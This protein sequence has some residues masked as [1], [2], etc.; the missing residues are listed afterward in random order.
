MPEKAENRKDLTQIE[1]NF[2]QRDAILLFA[3]FY[4]RAPGASSLFDRLSNA[5]HVIGCLSGRSGG[6]VMQSLQ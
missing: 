3:D 6:V 2:V 4:P 5:L 1:P